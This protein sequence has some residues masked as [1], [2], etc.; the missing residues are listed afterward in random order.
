MEEISISSRKVYVRQ[1]ISWAENSD[2]N[3]TMELILKRLS[4]NSIV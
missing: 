4:L 1:F 3:F 2:E